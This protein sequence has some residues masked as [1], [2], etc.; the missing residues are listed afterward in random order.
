[1]FNPGE[2]LGT[3][4]AADWWRSL[5]KKQRRPFLDAALDVGANPVSPYA[6]FA[7]LDRVHH[8]L[9]R[10]EPVRTWEPIK[11]GLTPQEVLERVARRFHAGRV[12][13][14]LDEHGHVREVHLVQAHR[15]LVAL[16]DMPERPERTPADLEQIA[17]AAAAVR[18]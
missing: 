10:P 3:T 9:G 12:L 4:R 17:Q 1:M 14:E 2:S 13:V 16:G 15:R 11:P 6:F 8:V 5:S 18:P 7:W